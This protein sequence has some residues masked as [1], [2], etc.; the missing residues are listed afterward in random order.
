MGTAIAGQARRVS[1]GMS[2]GAAL[3]ILGEFASAL[4]PRGFPGSESAAGR[5]ARCVSGG[6]SARVVEG[7]ADPDELLGPPPK[8]RGVSRKF[9][10]FLAYRQR[11]VIYAHGAQN[12]LKQQVG[13]SRTAI[14]EFSY[15][16]DGTRTLTGSPGHVTVGHYIKDKEEKQTVGIGFKWVRHCCNALTCFTCAPKIHFK[17]SQEV[18]AIV[19]TM[20]KKGYKILFVTFTAPHYFD[21]DPSIQIEKFSNAV[22]LFKSGRF[23]EDVKERYGYEYQIRAVELTCDAPDNPKKSGFHYHHHCIF[24]F[25]RKGNAFS[26]SELQDIKKSFKERWVHY[27]KK[28][29]IEV[30]ST[31]EDLYKRALDVQAP[32][33]PRRAFKED[34]DAKNELSRYISKGAAMELT[35]S[36]T[37]KGAKIIGRISHWEFMTLAL[38]T[39]PELQGDM[40]SI[41]KALKGKAWL[42]YSNGLR[43]I[44]GIKDV[45]DKE[46]MRDEQK[47]KPL[48]EFD[49]EM[50]DLGISWSNIDRYK[51]QSIFIECVERECEDYTSKLI[52]E[53]GGIFS[54]D[55]LYAIYN[56]D[57]HEVAYLISKKK[58][59]P[60]TGEDL[61][62]G[63]TLEDALRREDDE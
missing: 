51:M 2:A 47:G 24:F 61:Q 25:N 35:P 42:L 31:E 57:I 14:P 38:T 30:R 4:Q 18:E 46:I 43:K 11:R 20:Y 36:I 53:G 33:S 39:R 17:R 32:R 15:A 19:D 8:K 50:R 45:S 12:E 44:C 16:K 7:T 55:D 37:A 3:G 10:E 49:D 23:W 27:I 62:T 56:T 40:I 1:G 9:R 28:C 58:V 21:T 5:P 60:D 26:T 48:F 22:R 59:F 54:F 13:C 34:A 52:E 41:M 63:R 29:G 6:M